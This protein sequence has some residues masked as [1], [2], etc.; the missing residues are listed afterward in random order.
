MATHR[1]TVQRR[2]QPRDRAEW[3]RWKDRL[4]DALTA[5]VGAGMNE[6][7]GY[8]YGNMFDRGLTVEQAAEYI[9]N[10]EAMR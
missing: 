1:K 2:K 6:L 7:S 5:R 10:S 9:K 8:D 4:D 3:I